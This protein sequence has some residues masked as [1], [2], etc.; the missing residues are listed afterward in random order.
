M[1]MFDEIKKKYILGFDEKLK[2][3]RSYLDAKDVYE[4]RMAGHKLH[5]SGGSYGFKKIS[6]I[7]KMINSFAHQ[8]DWSGIEKEYTKLVSYIA[9]CRKELNLD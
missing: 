1:L 3:L 2:E 8:E 4:M 9:E 7:G 6:E 5:G